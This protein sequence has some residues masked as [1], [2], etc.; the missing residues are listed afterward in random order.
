MMHTS[1]YTAQLPPPPSPLLPPATPS[2][3]CMALSHRET[4]FYVYV[5]LTTVTNLITSGTA[6]HHTSNLE[7]I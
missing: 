2:T 7:A 1:D 5:L 4:H 6:G 3:P